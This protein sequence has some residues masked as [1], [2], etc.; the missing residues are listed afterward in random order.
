MFVF[1]D[2]LVGFSVLVGIVW[3]FPCWKLEEE[4][5]VCKPQIVVGG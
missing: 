4:L 1:R 5:T 2:I 3:D